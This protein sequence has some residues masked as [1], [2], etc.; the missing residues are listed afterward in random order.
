MFPLTR[1]PFWYRVFE[2]QPYGFVSNLGDAASKRKIAT[3]IG[4][5]PLL[6]AGLRKA[7]RTILGPARQ[8]KGP[9]LFL[10]F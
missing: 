5:A 3:P 6:W 8:T 2:P 10:W 4:G 7:Q 9:G 1:V